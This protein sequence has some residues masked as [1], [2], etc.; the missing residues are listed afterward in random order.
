MYQRLLRSISLVKRTVIGK[1]QAC[2]SVMQGIPITDHINI[3]FIDTTINTGFPGG[4]GM[5]RVVT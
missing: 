3:A 2:K 1:V 5:T 4:I